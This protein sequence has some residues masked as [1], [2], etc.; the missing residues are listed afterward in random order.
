MKNQKRVLVTGGAGFLGSHLCERLL[1]DGN[2]VI[3]LDNFFTGY[4]KNLINFHDKSNFEILEHDIIEAIHIEV[5]EIYNLACPASP[6]HY[7]KYP[8]QTLRT[9]IEG[10][11]NMLEL[12]AKLHVPMFQASTSEVYGNPKV[13][14]QSEEYFGNVNITGPRACYDEGKRAAETA[15]YNYQRQL[16]VDVRVAR[17]FNSYGPRMAINDGRV[18]SNFTVQALQDKNLTIYGDGAQT[19]SFCYFS[20]LIEGIVKLMK[21]PKGLEGAVNLGNPNEFTVK[22]LAETIITLTESKS[23][24]THSSALKDDPLQRCPDITKAKKLL[25]WI[26]GVDLKDGLEETISYFKK[27]I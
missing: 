26:P 22:E 15:C 9:C 27:I 14:P 10:T 17:I 16:G 1:R 11:I 13:H 12:S 2:K 25:K 7:Q 4:K 6:I 24:L 21:V 5:D 20:D 8:I 3:C 19:R 23:I 18:I